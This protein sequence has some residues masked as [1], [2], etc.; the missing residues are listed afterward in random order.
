MFLV[1][2]QSARTNRSCEVNFDKE[3]SFLEGGAGLNECEVWRRV[4]LPRSKFFESA[5]L[6]SLPRMLGAVPPKGHR[7]LATLVLK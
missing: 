6:S 5:R 2:A 7:F 3:K 4:L 1:S